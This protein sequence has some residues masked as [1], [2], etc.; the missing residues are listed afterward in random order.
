MT[1]RRWVT[2]ACI[3]LLSLAGCSEGEASPDGS[4]PTATAPSETTA[5][6]PATSKASTPE[7]LASQDAMTAFEEMLRV[8]D[9]ASRD[10]GTR[11]WEQD[12]RRYAADPA[13]FLAVQ[14]VRDL[15]TLG[16]RQEGDSR[17]DVE[18]A[19]VDLEAPE[20]PT[21]RLTACY[22]SQS[23]QIVDVATGE[24][25]PP[26]TPPHYVWDISIIRYV[27]EPGEPWLVSRLDPL[28]DQP[29]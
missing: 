25:V 14:S 24:V 28:T 5:T 21:V 4:S 23:A 7:E 17:V 19:A 6:P 27:E 22:D 11:D 16:L 8:T 12:I 15:A 10:P 9:A 1:V 13:A 20:G 18:V 26:G 3:A 2:G 29:C